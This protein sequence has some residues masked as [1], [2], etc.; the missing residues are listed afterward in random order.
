MFKTKTYD[1]RWFVRLIAYR[2]FLVMSLWY[3]VA[4][5]TPGTDAEAF[6]IDVVTTIVEIQSGNLLDT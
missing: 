6:A 4:A 5:N 1:R 2:L 3:A